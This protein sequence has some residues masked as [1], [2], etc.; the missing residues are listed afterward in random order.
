[1]SDTNIPKIPKY[2][3]PNPEEIEALSRNFFVGPG[4]DDTFK[5]WGEIAVELSL[6][7]L[8]NPEKRKIHADV[9]LPELADIFN[10]VELPE[11]GEPI[12]N[13]FQECQER[14]LNN[15]VRVNNPR[16]IG[17]MTTIVPW[18]SVVVNILITSINQNQVKIETALASS[19]VERQILSWLHRLVFQKSQDYYKQMVHSHEIALGNVTGGGTMGNLTALAVA[20]EKALP[21]VGK[22]GLCRILMG[23]GYS[24]VVIL[25]SRRVHYSIKK[26]A[27]VLGLGESSVLEIPVDR[28][29]RIEV[30][31]LK[32]QIN[33][34]KASNTL[35]LAIIGIAGTTETGNIDPLSK[36]AEISKKEKI[37]FHVD[38]AWG[39]PLLMSEE[40]KPMLSGIEKADSVVLDAHK[41]FYIPMS[42][43]FV[44]FKDEESLS[45]LQ[46][47]A[48]YVIRKGSVDLGQ[49]SLEGSRRFDV[50]KLWFSLKMLG[51]E[52]YNVLLKRSIQLL[53]TLKELI[54]E[55]PDFER[56]SEPEA[57]IITYRFVSK[58][59]KESLDKSLLKRRHH[60]ID[61]INDKL[62]RVNVELQKRQREYGFSFVS[63]TILESTIYPKKIVVL[64]AVTTNIM[65]RLEFL[66]E[67]LEEQKKIGLEIL[68]EN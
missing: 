55:H 11:K 47:Y 5:K 52:G 20:R 29:N 8:K 26:A 46:H 58:Y 23:K 21:G 66:E 10:E 64:R 42:L 67:I 50:L 35:I 33:W 57:C 43:G 36:L 12:E 41:L 17:H 44:L 56:T 37:W 4:N 24:N 3:L 27:A 65:T 48:N 49:R 51:K 13:V 62:N 18:F 16:Y 1:M 60:E 19:F 39:G 40:L 25:A 61:E 68:S 63:R 59:W 7:W 6:D 15:S 9:T 30:S 28:F 22:H 14:I 53:N 34:L 45:A 31:A 54:D 32:E 38:A 2:V